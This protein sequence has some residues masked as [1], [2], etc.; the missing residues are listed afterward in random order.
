MNQNNRVLKILQTLL[1]KVD[2]DTILERYDYVETARKAT[3][4]E[5]LYT[6]VLSSLKGWKSF[7]DAERQL[8]TDSDRRLRQSCRPARYLSETFL[9]KKNIGSIEVPSIIHFIN[10]ISDKGFNN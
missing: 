3:Y 6:W 10:S 7:R 1:D 4:K 8:K 9:Q 5:L 2:F